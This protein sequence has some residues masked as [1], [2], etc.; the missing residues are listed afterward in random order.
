MITQDQLKELEQR[1]Q[2]LYDYLKIEDNVFELKEDELK[3]QDPTFWDDP[4]AAEVVMKKIVFNF[5]SVGIF[6][7]IFF[8]ILS[9]CFFFIV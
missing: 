6:F 9:I 8:K 1:I 7:L 2:E 5:L 3:T 4:K